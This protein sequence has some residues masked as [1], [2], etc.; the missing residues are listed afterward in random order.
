MAVVRPPAEPAAV[1]P[2]PEPPVI[3]DQYHIAFHVEAAPGTPGDPLL[4]LDD[5]RSLIGDVN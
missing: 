4:P 1:E 3:E 2:P 5:Y